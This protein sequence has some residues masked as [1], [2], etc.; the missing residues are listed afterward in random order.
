MSYTLHIDNDKKQISGSAI[1]ATSTNVN[2]GAAVA[3][4]TMA[5]TDSALG[6]QVPLGNAMNGYSQVVQSKSVF[7]AFHT[8]PISLTSVASASGKCRFT[9]N[10]HGRSVGDIINVTGSTSGNVDGIHKITAVATNTFDT[11]KAYVASA[12]AGS[13]T[14]VSGDFAEMTVG[15]YLIRGGVSHEVA[16]G[17]YTFNQFGS[18]FGVRNAIHKLESIRTRRIATAIRAGYWNEFSGSWST[19]PTVASDSFG[20]DEAARPTRAI[21]GE[22]TYRISGQPDGTNGVTQ[23]DYE[24]KNGG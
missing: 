5:P 1:T 11:D 7:G 21:P 3:L 6:A 12:N 8:T 14:R 2:G 20:N 23:D 9:K 18:D 13:Y 22:L 19:K 15:S 4:G 24:A 16:G 10:S 17:E